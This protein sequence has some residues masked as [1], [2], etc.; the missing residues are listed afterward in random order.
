MRLIDGHRV[1]LTML[2]KND[3]HTTIT[4]DF[5]TVIVVWRLFFVNS[6]RLSSFQNFLLLYTRTVVT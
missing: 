4:V 5:L 3:R 1:V 6:R 2:T